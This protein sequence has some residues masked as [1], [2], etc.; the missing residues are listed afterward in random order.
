MRKQTHMQPPCYIEN[1]EAVHVY[2]KVPSGDGVVFYK[3]LAGADRR[4]AV[5]F[6]GWLG[7]GP[8]NRAVGYDQGVGTCLS[9]SFCKGIGGCFCPVVAG[10]KGKGGG[11]KRQREEG[12]NR[13]FGEFE[14]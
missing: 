7:S 3:N 13:L 1:L 14:F 10:V 6:A 11:T 9:L 2:G 5:V 8:F 12:V 4:G